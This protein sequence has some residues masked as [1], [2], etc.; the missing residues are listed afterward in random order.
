MHE[1]VRT[2]I[3]IICEHYLVRFECGNYWGELDGTDSM[4][5]CPECRAHCFRVS[6]RKGVA[7]CVS[8]GC[9]VPERLTAS[10][11]IAVLG[12]F[13]ARTQKREI[14]RER[15]SI[16]NQDELS[17]R[18]H[19]EARRNRAEALE[20]LRHHEV[21]ETKREQDGRRNEALRAWEAGYTLE[22]REVLARELV[23]RRRAG[24]PEGLAELR[25]E[26]EARTR[27]HLSRLLHGEARI[28]GQEAR[29]CALV[30]VFAL[31][32]VFYLVPLLQALGV[33]LPGWLVVHRFAVGL[34]C[35]CLAAC[36]FWWSH[37]GVRRGLSG[38]GDDEYVVIFRLDD[39][40]RM[41]WR[42]NT[43]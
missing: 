12:D 40:G 35:G 27:R 16:L 42:D 29:A 32:G 8:R 13:D 3:E 7:G 1:D 17:R 14:N 39:E 5:Q 25:E 38:L 28:T 19:A 31:A 18:R 33:P 43:R 4:W 11:V 24:T 20:E 26:A 9:G 34:V 30:W 36:A 6:G 23:R 10:Q 15:R 41:R 37:S 2:E 22:E 21:L